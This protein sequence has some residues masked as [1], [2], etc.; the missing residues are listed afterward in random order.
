MVWLLGSY[1]YYRANFGLKTNDTLEAPGVD[2]DDGPY[3]G[4]VALGMCCTGPRRLL[5]FY[6]NMR[7]N[8][9]LMVL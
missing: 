8:D 6:G 2:V 7:A 4:R 9:L 3:Y 1:I 5:K